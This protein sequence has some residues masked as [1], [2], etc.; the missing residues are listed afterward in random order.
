MAWCKCQCQLVYSIVTNTPSQLLDLTTFT[1][2][3]HKMPSAF[4]LPPKID[5]HY[6]SLPKIVPEEWDQYARVGVQNHMGPATTAEILQ[7]LNQEFSDEMKQLLEEFLVCL[8]KS[9]KYL[10]KSLV[11]QFVSQLIFKQRLLQVEVDEGKLEPLIQEFI[12]RQYTTYGKFAY[13]IPMP[14]LKKF[15]DERPALAGLEVPEEDTDQLFCDK[16]Q[17][18][19]ERYKSYTFEMSTKNIYTLTELAMVRVPQRDNPEGPNLVGVIAADRLAE[20]EEIGRG[21]HFIKFPIICECMQAYGPRFVPSLYTNGCFTK[22]QRDELRTYMIEPIVTFA[23]INFQIKHLCKELLD[24]LGCKPDPAPYE[25]KIQFLIDFIQYIKLLNG[26]LK[27][28]TVLI[29]SSTIQDPLFFFQLCKY[30]NITPFFFPPRSL[31]ITDPFMRIVLPKV[32]EEFGIFMGKGKL[33]DFKVN[34]NFTIQEYFQVYLEASD[35]AAD[36]LQDPDWIADIFSKQHFEFNETKIKQALHDFCSVTPMHFPGG[37]WRELSNRTNRWNYLALPEVVSAM[38]ALYAYQQVTN[39]TDWKDQ[40]LFGQRYEP[41]PDAPMEKR[42]KKVA[43]D[44]DRVIKDL[45]VLKKFPE[46]P[47]LAGGALTRDTLM[48]MNQEAIKIKM[49]EMKLL[50]KQLASIAKQR[51]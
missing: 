22:E 24:V 49:L 3:Q 26:D 47:F 4:A 36:S 33:T 39:L 34:G 14:W 25:I 42:R 1:L 31:H 9:N 5:L 41:Y 12:D 28:E 29:V 6:L 17:S 19:E 46:R 51:V 11:D 27:R 44:L 40:H 7:C 38:E 30:G 23:R 15:I 45:V 20:M 32:Q 21:N 10:Y 16:I 18:F 2:L 43:A 48:T 37:F 8:G 35:W 50:Q 13:D